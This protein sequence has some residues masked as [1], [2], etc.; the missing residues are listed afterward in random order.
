M[1]LILV[2]KIKD[3]KKGFCKYVNSKRKTR[4]NRGTLLNAV[5]ALEKEYTQKVEILNVFFASAFTA[6]AAPQKSQ[7]TKMRVWGKED[8]HLVEEDLIRDCID[9]FNTQKSMDADGIY[10]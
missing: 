1:E 8:F 5:G 2:R 3:Y 6:T 9:I 7:I 10:S 4:E